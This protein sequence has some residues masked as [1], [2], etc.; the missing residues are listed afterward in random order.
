MVESYSSIIRGAG[1]GLGVR[2]GRVVMGVWVQPWLG[3]KYTGRD[4]GALQQALDEREG[5]FGIKGWAFG[6]GGT[7]PP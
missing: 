4:D 7:P 3:P 2:V 6:D 5:G 1:V